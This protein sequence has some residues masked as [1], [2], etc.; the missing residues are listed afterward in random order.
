MELILRV[1]GLML[2]PSLLLF[3]CPDDVSSLFLV[4]VVDVVCT[5]EWDRSSNCDWAR[6]VNNGE[7]MVGKG[8][9]RSNDASLLLA[10]LSSSSWLY[11]PVVN[12]SLGHDVALYE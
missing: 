10:S 9:C 4:C 6:L 8:L 3:V 12:I 1:F 7:G 5:S 11:S 2:L